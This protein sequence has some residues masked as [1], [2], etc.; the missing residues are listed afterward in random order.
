MATPNTALVLGATGGVGYETARALLRH[1]WRIRAL[2]RSPERTAALL[3]EAEWRAGD[4]MKAPDVTAAA[5]GAALIV[6]GVNPPGYRN[7]RQLALP[8]LENTIAAARRS[9]ARIAFP[10]AIYNYGPEVFPLVDEDAP[11]NPHTRKG[12][13][14]VAMERR[15]QRAAEEDGL[16]ILILRGGDF[17][18]PHMGNSW[19]SQVLVKPGAPLKAITYPG[20]PEVGHTW[21]YLP[22]FAEA[23]ARLAE[24]KA[25]TGVFES[26]HFE[27]HWFPRG[28]EIAERIRIAAGATELPIRYFPW[29]VVKLS[30]PF[31]RLFRELV[32]MQYLWTT[33]LRLDNSRLRAALGKEPHTDID[34]ALQRTLVALGCVAR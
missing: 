2:H 31:V 19:F 32:E 28:G 11:Q 16:R 25:E 34:L 27:G 23:V 30:S 6:H 5:E 22:D 10:G 24:R 21:A 8:M 14:R 3:P 12:A 33:P 26:Y 29:G 13:I 15:L 18:G 7:W 17:F 9:G 1:G 20:R 4:A